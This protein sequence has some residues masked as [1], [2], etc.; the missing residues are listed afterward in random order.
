MLLASLI[1]KILWFF[2]RIAVDHISKLEI[3]NLDANIHYY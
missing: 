3:Y 1:S 2:N